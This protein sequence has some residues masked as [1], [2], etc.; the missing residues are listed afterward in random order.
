MLLL[1][2][3]PDSAILSKRVKLVI[4]HNTQ[5]E[6]RTGHQSTSGLHQR[7]LEIPH[8]QSLS[9]VWLKGTSRMEI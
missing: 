6:P 3:L 2:E 1:I 8:S 5:H 9:S 7:V 4:L